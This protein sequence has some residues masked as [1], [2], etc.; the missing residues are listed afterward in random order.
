MCLIKIN[1]EKSRSSCVTTCLHMMG[2]IIVYLKCLHF[3]LYD[4]FSL[5]YCETD[6]KQTS[7][8]RTL[9]DFRSRESDFNFQ[10]LI[11][12]LTILMSVLWGKRKD[13]HCIGEDCTRA[14]KIMN[15]KSFCFVLLRNFDRKETL[16][17]LF[18]QIH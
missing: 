14:E 2:N 10:M 16:A 9:E 18:S 5:L 15:N 8:I 7:S 17:T 4:H 6:L 1:K 12:T 3:Y 11:I 13:T